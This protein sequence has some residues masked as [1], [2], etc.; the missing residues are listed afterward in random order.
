MKYTTYTFISSR[1]VFLISVIVALLTIV[2][3]F[4]WGLG[5]HSTFFENSVLSTTIL[6][7]AFFVFITINLYRG[8]KL[9]EDVGSI[10]TDTLPFQA[11]ADIASNPPA[12]ESGPPMDVGDGLG[13]ILLGILLWIVWG[14]VVAVSIWFF[15]NV[16]LVVIA[17]FAA[18]LY[19]IFFRAMRLVFKNSPRT[20]GRIWTSVQYGFLY[21]FLY[22]FWIYGIFMLA[23]YM[24]A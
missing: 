17:A 22:N 2:S 14:I 24:K 8:V 3:V 23:E 6:S 20:K 16:L 7:V 4:F 19:W 21:T 15:A 1:S 10:T 5:H 18:M 12:S 9:K 11:A 13:G